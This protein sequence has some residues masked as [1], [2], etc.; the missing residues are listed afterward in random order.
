[1]NKQEKIDIIKNG[2]IVRVCDIVAF[3]VCC[4][5]V[6]LVIILLSLRT[7]GESVQV[8]ADGELYSE[9][10]LSTDVSFDI[11]GVCIVISDGE[12]YVECAD[13]DDHICMLFGSIS[14]VNETIICVPNGVVIKVVGQSDLSAVI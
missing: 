9:Y 6:V 10:S 14:L 8:Y 13:C 4:A 5:V 11:N 1:M 12:C 3:A 2:K 7:E